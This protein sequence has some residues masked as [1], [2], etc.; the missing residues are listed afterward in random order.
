MNLTYFR[1]LTDRLCGLDPTALPRPF[2]EL[3][4]R[5]KELAKSHTMQFFELARRCT[6]GPDVE[7]TTSETAKLTPLLLPDGQ[8][9]PLVMEFFDRYLHPRVV[10]ETDQFTRNE[11]TSR[12]VRPSDRYVVSFIVG[13]REQVDSPREAALAALDA[14]RD[15]DADDTVWAV[16]DRVTGRFYEFPQRD[17]EDTSIPDTI[18]NIKLGLIDAEVETEDGEAV[19]PAGAYADHAREEA[20]A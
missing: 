1:N 7:P 16:F 11:V 13:Y 17:F 9:H 10:A 12:F 14:T 6:C 4:S 18:P 2:N 8:P 15:L 19:R 20:T 3:H 5:L